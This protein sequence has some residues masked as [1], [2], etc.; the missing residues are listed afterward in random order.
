[1]GLTEPRL[2]L[3][4]SLVTGEGGKLWIGQ[5][6]TGL[7]RFDTLSGQIDRIVPCGRDTSEGFRIAGLGRDVERS[8][9]VAS[10]HNGLGRVET[11]SNPFELI[12]EDATGA[13]LGHPDVLAIAGDASGGLWIGTW[14]GWSR[15]SR[16]PTS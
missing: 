8:L 13:R 14:G 15:S 1:M 11:G 3:V 10:W 12:S 6:G 2:R 9:W 7:E 5:W 16:R 4:T